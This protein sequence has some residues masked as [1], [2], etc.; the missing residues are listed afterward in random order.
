MIIYFSGTGNTAFTAKLLSKALNDEQLLRLTS[1]MLL[2]PENHTLISK[3]TRLI[4]AFPIYSWG[5]P[6]VIVNFIRKVKIAWETKDAIHY[7]LTTCGDDMG[8][9]DLRWRKE[10]RRRGL[11]AKSVFAVR[12]PNTYVCMKGFNVDPDDLEQEKLDK[13]SDAIRKI[14]DAINNGKEDILIRKSFSWIKT[15]IIYPWFKKYAMSSRPFYFTQACISC[16]KCAAYCP[17]ANISMIDRH[18]FWSENCAMCLRCYHIC[19]SHAVAY[20][21]ATASKGQYTTALKHLYNGEL[22]IDKK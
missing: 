18:P 21:K 14:A 6:P 22:S 19:P 4:W 20:G 15:Y 10:I 9:A 12:M 7:M 16:G 8:Y 1:D 17:M 13:A 3:D 2:H 11:N 5:I